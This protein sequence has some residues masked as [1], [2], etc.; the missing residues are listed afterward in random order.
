M[1]HFT[2]SCQMR[3]PHMQKSACLYSGQIKEVNKLPHHTEKTVAGPSSVA[4]H[5]HTDSTGKGLNQTKAKPHHPPWA[6]ST[7][8]TPG[9]QQQCAQKT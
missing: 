8:N 6:E 9:N 7:A 3:F 5:L 4:N 1:A 2:T